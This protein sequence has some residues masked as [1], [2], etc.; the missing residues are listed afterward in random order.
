[1]KRSNRRAGWL[2]LVATGV[3]G[4]VIAAVDEGAPRTNADVAADISRDFACPVCDGQSVAES[5]V[6]AALAVRQEIRS[7]VDDGRSPGEIRDRL[8]EVY[9]EAIDLRPRSGGFVG[10]V[11]VLPVVAFVA[12]AAGLV[13]V[14]RRWR[15][16]WSGDRE[17]SDEDRSLVGAALAAG[18]D[19]EEPAGETVDP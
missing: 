3:A 12:G 18:D 6:P 1:M 10:L 7:M 2:A 16:P 4:L 13:A 8:V 5:D 14:F 17:V 15:S 9:G 19:P 11:W